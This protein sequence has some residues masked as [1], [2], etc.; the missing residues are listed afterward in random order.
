MNKVPFVD[1]DRKYG[2]GSLALHEVF[3]VP[4]LAKS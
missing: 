1:E 2:L 4:V 3:G